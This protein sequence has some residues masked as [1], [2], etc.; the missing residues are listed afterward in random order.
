M[1]SL[2]IHPGL[3]R[4][5]LVAAARARLQG[6]PPCDWTDLVE[7]ADICASSRAVNRA[8]THLAEEGLIEGVYTRSGWMYLHATA[9]GVRRAGGAARRP[10]KERRATPSGTVD[11]RGMFLDEQTAAAIGPA[12]DPGAAAAAENN[13]VSTAEDTAASPTARLSAFLSLRVLAL[14]AQLAQALNVFRTLP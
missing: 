14:R 4:H 1:Q 11:A 9:R 8:L 5:L 13:A 7:R 6:E 2:G 12:L 3:T 10:P